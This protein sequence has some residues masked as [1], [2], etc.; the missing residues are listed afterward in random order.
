[1]TNNQNPLDAIAFDVSE[2]NISRN[3]KLSE[4]ASKCG[5]K[6]LML[7][8][9]IIAGVQNIRD[10][11]G[12]SIR[13]NSGFRTTEHNASPAVGGSPNSLHTLGMAVDL[14][15]VSGKANELTRIITVAGSLGFVVRPYP[16]FVHIDCGKVR[17][18]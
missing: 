17:N 5:A 12:F 16:T 6:R 1:M 3:F 11:C 4:Y 13:I 14:S 9:S 7:H 8:P 2:R 15:P 18:W 10:A